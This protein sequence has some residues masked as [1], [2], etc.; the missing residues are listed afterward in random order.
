[1]TTQ[2][3][4]TEVK[5]KLLSVLDAVAAGDEIEITRHGRTV[6]RLVPATG[7]S[8]L[9]GRLAGVAM[10]AARGEGLVS[11]GVR[12]WSA[13]PERLSPAATEALAAA[14]QLAVSA[15]SWFELAWLAAHERIIV[16]IPVRPSLERL[17]ARPRTRAGTPAE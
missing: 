4:A 16:T 6:A 11:P 3:T 8:V 9:R 5:A 12:W 13:E 14:D 1:M 15:I 17:G 7:P 2:M 10:G